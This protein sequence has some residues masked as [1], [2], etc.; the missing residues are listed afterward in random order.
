MRDENNCV[1]ENPPNIYKTLEKELKNEY[2]QVLYI[3][4]FI[5]GGYYK[6][7]FFTYEETQ[8]I[9]E[10]VISICGLPSNYTREEIMNDVFLSGEEWNAFYPEGGIKGDCLAWGNRL[11]LPTPG[12]KYE[13]PRIISLGVEKFEE[14]NQENWLDL[15][16][17]YFIRIRAPYAEKTPQILQHA[18]NESICNMINATS[19]EQG[20]MKVGLKNPGAIIAEMKGGGII[21]PSVHYG[22]FLRKPEVLSNS[23]EEGRLMKKFLEGAPIY[24]LNKALV[25]WFLVK[26][27]TRSPKTDWCFS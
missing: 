7:R 12:E 25:T 22:I 17:E 2:K 16:K 9:M 11:N 21:S 20:C 19:I 26:E 8:L 10:R 4:A 23:D 15:V 18:I 6:Q 13:I 5:L 24:Q 14:Q 1:I 27:T 3:I